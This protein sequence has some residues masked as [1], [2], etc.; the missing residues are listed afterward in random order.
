ML[1]FALRYLVLLPALLLAVAVGSVLGVRAF[2]QSANSADARIVS[3]RGINEAGYVQLGGARQ[4]VTIRGQDRRQPILVYLHG[5]PGGTTSDLAYSFQ[6]PWE[7]YFTVVQWD[8]RGFGRS[9]IDGEALRG[10]ITK[11]QLVDDAIALIEHLRRR[12]G[13][14]KVILLGHSWGTVLG[15]EVAKRRPDLLYAY[16]GF[17]QLT[18]WKRNM[19]ETR[20]ALAEIGRTTGNA[21]LVKAMADAGPAP[22]AHD[23][24]AFSA[25][26]AKIQTHL[27]AARG[28]WYNSAGAKDIASRMLMTAFASPT[29]SLRGMWRMLNTDAELA[30]DPLMASVADWDFR[31]TLGRDFDVPMIFVSGR[32]DLQTPMAAAARLAAELCAPHTEMIV[33][34]NSAHFLVTEEPGRVLGALLK[35][36]PFAEGAAP[37]AEPECKAETARGRHLTVPASPP[38]SRSA[39]PRG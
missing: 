29:L 30:L 13:Q 33:I 12:T 39:A 17:G 14:Q 1:R 32:H 3:P 20:A 9:A 22:D 23:T 27:S 19:E 38:S 16:V 25:W 4:W 15:A 36:R 5:G 31:E 37:A 18:G 28:S 10:T 26:I 34:E 35:V 24:E 8:Q 2:L 11:T 6:R 21:A 7:D